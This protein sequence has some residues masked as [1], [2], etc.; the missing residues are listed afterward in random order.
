MIGN[1]LQFTASV[2]DQFI[3][4]KFGLD[5][6]KVM[7]NCLIEANGSIPQRNQ[8]K[9]VLSLINVEKETNIPFYA[10]NQLAGSKVS[11]D[12]NPEQRFNLDLLISANFDDYNETLKFLDVILL[13]FQAHP[14]LNAK[15]F[16]LMP[17]G[18]SKLEFDVEKITYREMQNLWTAMGAKYQP[19]VIY[20][21]RLITIQANEAAGFNTTVS[22][23]ANSA[24]V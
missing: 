23:T 17:S 14:C 6:S 1:A 11:L 18:L 10:Y 13:F 15:S 22:K 12:I 20:K 24:T 4:N 3:K 16:P 21:L 7:L 9:V 5:E 2:L 8:N 19:S